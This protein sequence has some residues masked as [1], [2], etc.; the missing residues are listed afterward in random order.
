MLK[1]S[2][3][4]II[5]LVISHCCL[6]A[7]GQG[8]FLKSVPHMQQELSSLCKPIILLLCGVS[9]GVAIATAFLF[10]KLTID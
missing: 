5:N 2:S 9:I 3:K 4:L 8:K 10:L 6:A 1:L 7:R